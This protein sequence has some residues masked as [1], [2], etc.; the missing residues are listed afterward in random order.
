MASTYWSRVERGRIVPG[1]RVAE[2]MAT[3][4]GTTLSEL[5]ADENEA[6]LLGPDLT[7]VV[8]RLRRAAIAIT[9]ADSTVSGLI[10]D[11]EGMPRGGVAPHG[12]KSS[13]RS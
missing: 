1:I 11:L 5:V 7:D 13:K 4:L 6:E 8:S 12:Q 10:S 2:R 9:V 3:V